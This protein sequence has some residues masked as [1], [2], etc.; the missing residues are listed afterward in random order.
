MKKIMLFFIFY[1]SLNFIHAQNTF[2]TYQ[3]NPQWEMIFDSGYN[4]EPFTI[5]LKE[6]TLICGELWTPVENTNTDFTFIA[7]R[8]G[9]IRQQGQ[10]VFVRKTANCDEDIR[11]MFDFSAEIG[12]TLTVG[13]GG[14]IPLSTL[15]VVVNG[16][17]TL[18]VNGIERTTVSV[19]HDDPF[20]PISFL[21]VE[22]IGNMFQQ[23]P[24]YSLECLP[25]TCSE[26]GFIFTC[27]YENGNL[28]YSIPSPFFSCENLIDTLHVNQNILTGNEDGS[29]WGNAFFDLQDA[30]SIAD[31]STVVLVAQGTYF[32]TDTDDRTVSF[33]ISDG[34]Q[35]WGG[36][37]GNETNIIDRDVAA[38]PTILSGDISTVG[39]ATDNSY[40]VL[41]GFNIDSTTLVDGF[42]VE[43]GNANGASVSTI[44]G[45]GGG[46][47]IDANNANPNANPTIRNCIFRDNSADRGGGIYSK[48]RSN[49]PT[50]NNVS[51]CQF[52]NNAVTFSG[53]GVYKSG[54]FIGNQSTFFNCEFIDNNAVMGGG[55]FI[56]DLK[57]EQQIINCLFERDSAETEGGGIML[58][59]DN[60][61][62]SLLL[63]NSIIKDNEA[64]SGGG[65][66][67]VYENFNEN[68]ISNIIID[69]CQIINNSGRLSGG[70]GLYFN[71]VNGTHTINISK[72]ALRYNTCINGGGGI[73][74]ESETNTNINVTNCIFENNLVN[75][76][77]GCGAIYFAGA[78]NWN[79]SFDIRANIKNSLFFDNRDALGFFTGFGGNIE[80]K[81]NNCTFVN[82]DAHPFWKNSVPDPTPTFFNEWE[83]TN[84]IIWENVPV[85]ELFYNNNSSFSTING[86]TVRNSLVSV[87]NCIVDGIN[88]CEEGMIYQKNPLFRDSINGDFTLAGCSPAINAGKND[89][90]TVEDSLDLVGNLRILESIVDMGAFEHTSFSA[91]II[92]TMDVSC[93]GE[94]DGSIETNIQGDAPFQ[95]LWVMDSISG[96]NINQLA[97]GDYEFF[98]SDALGCTD[99][100]N[101]SINSP[102]S[103]SIFATINH[104]S[105]FQS[106]DGSIFIDSITG[107]IPPYSINWEMGDSTDFFDD[108]FVGSYSLQIIDANGCNKEVILEISALDNLQ[109]LERDNLFKIFPNPVKDKFQIHFSNKK[110]K[111][112]S[113][114]IFHV[115]G[116]KVIKQEFFIND[117]LEIDIADLPTGIYFLVLKID[118]EAFLYRKFVKQ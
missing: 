22:G 104:A 112:V 9:Y 90:L 21:W 50:L 25:Y 49:R 59:S 42:I 77:N 10:K 91:A 56:D 29:T 18:N 28:L 41:Y 86:Y 54:G 12:D 63:K 110:I 53:G 68:A 65:M 38:Y 60:D 61:D 17:G 103:L 75:N 92:D 57:G 83:F 11:L 19:L 55:I 109:I 2:P 58:I 74:I 7:G 107:G 46:F 43:K 79:F 73:Y 111:P 40:H 116:K 39:N 85:G 96:T 101:I 78:G 13:W 89:Y 70:G 4:F 98:L 100:I 31:S 118:K 105:T 47:L 72:S 6:D 113:F 87:P 71:M 84:C 20:T 45:K 14:S 117:N 24:L 76:G 80:L 37:L 93:F 102:D 115:N 62:F 1:L 8:R 23:H 95:T 88:A 67:Y 16:K 51:N 69:S 3:T 81:A 35:L 5:E 30:L 27:F 32:P 44:H 94:M 52:L 34:I 15:E 114:S 99:T 108:L 66:S 82:N 106:A 33:T 97:A 48:S 26:S 64:R 36:F